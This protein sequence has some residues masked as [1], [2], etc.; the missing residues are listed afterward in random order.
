M[1]FGSWLKDNARWVGLGLGGPA[2]YVIGDLA[3]GGPLSDWLGGTQRPDT[4]VGAA[5][6]MNFITPGGA[7]RANALNTL[8]RDYDARGAPQARDSAF[9]QYQASLMDRLQ[10]QMSGRDSLAGLQLRQATDENIAQQRALAASAGPQNAAMAQRLAMQNA[11]NLNQGFGSQAAM[12]GIQERNAAAQALGGVT[13]QARGQDLALNQFNAAQQLAARSANDQASANARQQE[14]NNAA[15]RQQ[16]N[17]GYEQNETMRRGQDFGVDQTQNWERLAGAAAP[18]A[19]FLMPTPTPAAKGGVFSKPTNALVGEAGPEAIIPLEDIPALIEEAGRKR[20]GDARTQGG[21]DEPTEYDQ[22]GYSYAKNIHPTPAAMAA[23]RAN[24]G[25]YPTS[26]K[27]DPRSGLQ[28]P[29][30]WKA[31]QESDPHQWPKNSPALDAAI[32]KQADYYPT[33]W[34][35]DERGNMVPSEWAPIPVKGRAKLAEGGVVSEPTPALIGEAGPEAV[36]PLN[37]LTAAQ[38]SPLYD[39]LQGAMGQAP[40]PGWGDPVRGAAPPA[41]APFTGGA[42]PSFG[43]QGNDQISEYQRG[44]MADRAGRTENPYAPRSKPVG[45]QWVN[46]QFMP[47]GYD[48]AQNARMGAW[49]K[50]QQAYD[51]ERR[52]AGNERLR[53]IHE[54]YVGPTRYQATGMR[55][56]RYQ[57]SYAPH[58][59]TGG[60]DNEEFTQTDYTQ[61]SSMVPRGMQTVSSSRPTMMARGG[62]VM[63]PTNAVVGERGPEAILPLPPLVAARTKQTGTKSSGGGGTMTPVPQAPMTPIRPTPPWAQTAARLAA[64]RND[65]EL[66]RLNPMVA[67]RKLRGERNV[68]E[69]PPAF[70]AQ[71][72]IVTEPTN[73]ILGEEGPE[74]VVPLGKLPGLIERIKEAQTGRPVEKPDARA[75]ANEI[76]N[77]LAGRSSDRYARNDEELNRFIGPDAPPPPLNPPPEYEVKVGEAQIEKP[78]PEYEVK[79]GKAQIEES[80][81]KKKKKKEK[82]AAPAAASPTTVTFGRP[83]IMEGPQPP[84][85]PQVDING[86]YNIGQLSRS[87]PPNPAMRPYDQANAW[88]HNQR[89]PNESRQPMTNFLP[90][91]RTREEWLAYFRGL[92]VQ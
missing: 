4:D 40:T 14:L 48:P 57:A 16:A 73:T 81:P 41:S 61:A 53:Q 84:E 43:F 69:Q 47:T 86:A 24:T 52:A 7:D 1:G 45:G 54:R 51:A 83:M 15:L 38:S 88:L 25:H 39:K 56:Q 21:F 82:K 76:V 68:F 19:K 75:Q 34:K 49:A 46:G 22:F 64:I 6:R 5:D 10:G 59:T 85:A 28:V 66:N 63:E 67:A 50:A 12:L 62:L 70:M 79:V 74:A 9:R 91:F 33:S 44:V 13:G 37:D 27:E 89:Y 3:S 42:S 77:R 55:P 8:A 35:R 78:E 17:M 58:N 20:G 92:G 65:E 18:F 90:Q 87:L 29:A 30:T 2:G 23:M 31:K 32:W 71:G 11:G 60:A 26:W 36:V 72:G 80:K